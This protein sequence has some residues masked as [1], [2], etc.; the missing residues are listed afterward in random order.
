MHGL[1]PDLVYHDDHVTR[2]VAE[3]NTVRI[4]SSQSSAE[5]NVAKVT[6]KWHIAIKPAL[7]FK[8]LYFRICVTLTAYRPSF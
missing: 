6:R 7:Q 8:S 1:R 5:Q 2:Q 4:E 3:I